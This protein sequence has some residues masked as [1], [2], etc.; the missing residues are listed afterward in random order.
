MSYNEAQEQAVAELDARQP[1]ESEDQTPVEGQE[2]NAEGQQQVTGGDPNWNPQE[3]QLKFR[4][5]VVVPKDRNHLINLAQ[6]GFSYSQR[7]QEMKSREDQLNAQKAQYDQY[8]KLEDAFARNPAFREQIMQWYQNSLTPGVT[9][10]QAAAAS[11]QQSS[12]P[13]ELLQEIQSL[14]EWKQNFESFQQQQQEQQ[15][16]N[17]IMSEIQQL[18]QKY[19]RDDWESPAS[20]GNSLLKE[21]IKH[22]Y[23]LGGVKLETAYRDLMWDSHTKQSEIGGMK[24]AAEAQAASRKAGVI[25][26]GRS[27]GAVP[28]QVDT[29][30]MGYSDIEKLIKSEY[31][32]NS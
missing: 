19:A 25:A 6:Q 20:N 17:E 1:N 9:Q 30:S 2:N 31:G 11:P 14:K 18:Q 15:A 28:K 16:D 24:K 32:I 8:A 27:K 10:S 26:G 5:Q 29:A 12:I 23:D 3:W 13:P 7:M 22:A 4:D 21:V